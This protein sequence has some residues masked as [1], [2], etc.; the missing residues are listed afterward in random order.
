SPL[1]AGEVLSHVAR[2]PAQASVGREQEGVARLVLKSLGDPA[3]L[4]EEAPCLPPPDSRDAADLEQCDGRGELE[5]ESL[6][7]LRNGGEERGDP[8]AVFHPIRRV[9]T[10]D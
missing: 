9:T 6:A 3:R 7:G 10:C 8:T 5:C 2:E 1:R 4:V